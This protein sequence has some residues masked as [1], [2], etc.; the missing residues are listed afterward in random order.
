MTIFAFEL[1]LKSTPLLLGLA[2]TIMSFQAVPHAIFP[3]TFG[4]TKEEFFELEKQR[5]RNVCVKEPVETKGERNLK[6]PG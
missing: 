2:N 5:L 3:F 4:S 6:W 1:A